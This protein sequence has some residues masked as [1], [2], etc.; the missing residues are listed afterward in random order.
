MIRKT[1]S[2]EI[3]VNELMRKYPHK[4]TD[5][6]TSS[7]A[8]EEGISYKGNRFYEDSARLR[9]QQ[10]FLGGELIFKV[11]EEDDAITE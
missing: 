7:L 3:R 8:R 1:L 9:R 10:L 6:R 5:L 4:S 11:L 2:A